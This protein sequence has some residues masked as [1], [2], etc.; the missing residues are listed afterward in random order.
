[1]VDGLAA[2]G[3][4]V[5]DDAVAFGEV[6]GGQVGGGFQQVAEGLAV[7]FF[8]VRCVG[9][10]DQEPVGGGLRVDVEEGEREVVLV[11]NLHG[12]FMSGDLTEEASGHI[13]DC[14]GCPTLAQLGW[15]CGSTLSTGSGPL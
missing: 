3:P 1:M 5:D 15:V 2:V 8:H 6:F 13:K 7:G 14:I 12:D 9:F 10:G 4:G 11:E